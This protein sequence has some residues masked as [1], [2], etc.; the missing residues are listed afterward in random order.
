MPTACNTRDDDVDKSKSSNPNDNNNSNPISQDDQN[1]LHSNH[2]NGDVTRNGDHQEEINKMQHGFI[3][4]DV[5]DE[6]PTRDQ[7]TSSPSSA[8]NETTNIKSSDNENS[9]LTEESLVLIPENTFT[10]KLSVPGI[11]PF[12]LQ[13]SPVELV[14]EINH[15]L[16]DREDTCHR[17]CFSLQLDGVTLDNFTELRNI[18][19]L[20]EGSIIKLVEEPYTVREARIHVRHIRDLL[21]SLDINDS[22]NGIDCNSLSFMNTI[23]QNDLSDLK[24]TNKTVRSDLIDCLPPDYVLPPENNNTSSINTTNQTNNTVINGHNFSGINREV[25][26]IPLQPQIKDVPKTP[27]L[28]IITNS[29]WNPP[30]GNRKLR[31]DL[32]YLYVVT[33]EDKRFHITSSVKGF[34]VNL[35]TD[36]VFNPKPSNPKLIFHSLVDLLSQ[37]SSAF[38]RNYSL[39]Q[40]RRYQRHPIERLVAPY[41]IYTWTAP[42]IDNTIDCIRAEDAFSSKLSYEEHMPGQTRDWNEELQTTRELPRKTLSERIIRERAIFKVHSDFVSAATRGAMAVVDGNVLAL[43]PNEDTKM[44][45]FIW[46]SIFFSL[47]FDVRD[48]YKEVG[49]DAAAYAAPSNDLHGVRAYS[50]IN[51]EGF[52]T[53]ATAVID[54]KGFRVTAQSIIPGILDRDQEQSVVYGSIDFGKTVVS[55]PK[56]L[57]ILKKAGQ[58]LKI[59]PHKVIS[60]NGEEIEICSSVECKGIIGNDGR[61]YILDLLRTFPPDP[62]YVLTDGS[63]LSEEMRKMGFPRN[64]KHKLSSLRQE[65]I[66]AFFESRYLMFIRMAAYYL[67]QSDSLHNQPQ[68]NLDQ[69]SVNTQTETSN[70]SSNT[71]AKESEIS[72]EMKKIAEKIVSTENDNE[73]KE[74]A[75]NLSGTSIVGYNTKEIVRKA[76]L[77]VGSLSETEFDIR[78]NPDIF[79]YGVLHADADTEMFKKQKQLIKDAAEFLIKVQIP[80]LIRELLDHTLYIYDGLT[81]TEAFRAR[82]INMRYLGYFVENLSQK[83]SLDYAMSI[84][85]SELVCRSIKHLFVSYMQTVE[86]LYMA[87]AISH[88]L[89]C[90]FSATVT[91]PVNFDDMN[92]HSKRRGR[93]MRN[94]KTL[95][96]NKQD[97]QNSDWLT[98]TPKSFWSQLRNEMDTYYGWQPSKEIESVEALLNRYSIQKI[99]ML[100][101]VCI[102]TGIQILLR[103]YNFDHKTRPAFTE[104]DILN[105]FPVVKHISPKAN[106]A[107]NLFQTGQRKISEGNIRDSYDYI[108]EAL[109]L[110]NSVYGPLHPDIVQCLR[111]LGRINYIL[112][113]YSEACIQQQKAVLMSEKVNGIDHPHTITEYNFLALYSFANSQISASLKFLYRTR[114]LLSLIHSQNHPEMAIVDSN[115]GLILHAIGEYD[116]SL[117]FLEHALQLN[118][119][120]FGNRNLKIALNYHLIARTLSCMGDF[121]GALNNEKETYLIY[122][123]ELGANH[124]KTKESSE[125][126]RHLTNQ[127]VVLQKKMNEIYKGNLNTFIPPIQIQPPSISSVMEL[128]NVING[129]LFLHI[130]TQDAESLR[131]IQTVKSKQSQQEK[132]DTLDTKSSDK[133]LKNGNIGNE[134]Q[135]SVGAKD[136]DHT[137]PTTDRLN[138]NIV[139]ASA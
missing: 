30:P 73:T 2:A 54:Y 107:F 22:Y 41:Q 102:R 105:V 9:N 57:E 112:G 10:I 40:K 21:K 25:Q 72:D 37:I 95:S 80:T 17:T 36:D 59:I 101:I 47:G 63:E 108:S 58:V 11:E 139:F 66:D 131:E 104:D 23:A 138:N 68:M 85:V 50:F 24:K 84:G 56:Y 39:I 128:L 78:F 62:H 18:E 19:G 129:I 132:D 8:P 121:R 51:V 26:L 33:L 134:S 16:I 93:K 96:E 34:F 135:A 126:L 124:E 125:C 38:K 118:L 113:D 90:F 137:S 83:D 114:Y 103:E 94:G 46:N 67:Q 119:R 3:D 88:F 120:Y 65:L 7:S 130:T 64:H 15:Q 55:H 127:A 48:H 77:D 79:S 1:V 106:D 117:K 12:E 123:K 98:L 136:E 27:A 53:L 32:M 4:D 69:S 14:Q 87:T 111:L 60:K 100:R 49:G 122:K 89:N 109:N 61:H 20:K 71:D 133:L 115:I 86:P 31:G 45:M 42:Q 81:L 43:N 35:S 70:D 82:G 13:V 74:S 29:G 28:K 5:D 99:S 75:S 76:A 52:S 6:M 110:F 92:K 97:R 44:Q 116:Y 91:Q